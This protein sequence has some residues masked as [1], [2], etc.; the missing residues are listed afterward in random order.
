MPNGVTTQLTYDAR[1]RLLT[2]T[3][4]T[5]AGPLTTSYTYDAAGNL[6]SVAQPGRLDLCV[7]PTTRRIA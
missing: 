7:T 4:N 2:R 3:V 1:Q 6:L 5:A